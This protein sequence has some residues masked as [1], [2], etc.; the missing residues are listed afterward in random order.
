MVQGEVALCASTTPSNQLFP[1]SRTWH[2]ENRRREIETNFHVFRYRNFR[3]FASPR[4][5]QFACVA[6]DSTGEFVAAGGHDVFEIYL[7]SMKIGRLL[8]VF[9]T[10]FLVHVKIPNTLSQNK[11]DLYGLQYL[12]LWLFTK[13]NIECLTCDYQNSRNLTLYFV[14][15]VCFSDKTSAN[16]C[17][18]QNK[19]KIPYCFVNISVILYLTK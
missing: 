7:W 5:V 10:S 3:T 4:P 2:M 11:C 16:Q 1:Q 18:Q 12:T 6:L 17:K 9:L 8:E 19:R 15:V 14:C 13:R